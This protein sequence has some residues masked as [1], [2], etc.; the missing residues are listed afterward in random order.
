MRDLVTRIASRA[1]AAKDLF[2]VGDW[3]LY[4]KYKNKKGKVK[5]FGKDEKGN[6]TVTVEPHPNE[7]GRK[8]PKTLQLF[9]IWKMPEAKEPTKKASLASLQWGEPTEVQAEKMGRTSTRFPFEV[10]D[11]ELRNPPSLDFTLWELGVLAQAAQER[12]EHLRFIQIADQD[13]TLLFRELCGSLGVEFPQADLE[14]LMEEA[15]PLILKLKFHW[16]RARPHQVAESH[17]LRFHAMPSLSAKSPAYPS[18]H[19]IQAQLVSQELIRRYPEHADIIKTMADK[20]SWTRV[21]AGYHWP[22]DLVYGEEVAEFMWV[23]QVEDN[24][25]TAAK[26]KNKKQVDK[27]DGSGKTTVY[28]YSEK[29]VQHRNREKAKRVEGLRKNI[30][31]LRVQVKKDV[32]SSDPST[33]LTALAVALIDETYERVGN[34]TSAKEGHFGVTGW[35]AGHVSFSGS[36]ATVSYVG[37][38]GVKQKKTVST[39][40]IVSALKAAVKGKG[41]EENVLCEG[42]DCNISASEVNAYLKPHGVTAKDLRGFHANESMK[43]HLKTIRKDGPKLPEDKKEREKLLKDEFKKALEEA[44]KDVGHEASTLKSQYLVPGLEDDYV[45]DGTINE[46]HASIQDAWGAL[47]VA[48]KSD[49]EKQEEKVEDLSKPAPKKK[50]PRHDLRKER[51]EDDDDD[52]KKDKDKKDT[53]MNYKDI[54]ASVDVLLTRQATLN[55][56]LGAAGDVPAKKHG[57]GDVWQ[58]DNGFRAIPAGGDPKKDGKTFKSQEEAKAYAQGGEDVSPEEEKSPEEDSPEGEEKTKPKVKKKDKPKK[59][60]KPAK[61]KPEDVLSVGGPLPSGDDSAPS[62]DDL[63]D[64]T[65]ATFNAYLKSS[66]QDREKALGLIQDARDSASPDSP[67]HKHL[68]AQMQ[69]LLL[70]SYVNDESVDD[71]PEPP[72]AL[73]GLMK[74]LA[75]GG[76]EK[77]VALAASLAGNPTTPDARKAITDGI[78]GMPANEL[79]T[80]A[81]DDPSMAPL[82]DM[83]TSGDKDQEAA[84]ASAMAR[85]I[86]SDAAFLVPSVHAL[87]DYNPEPGKTNPESSK[88]ADEV[89]AEVKASV[90]TQSALGAAFASA[91]VEDG[92][93]DPEKFESNFMVSYAKS[94]LDA[95]KAKFPTAPSDN[96]GM[97]MLETISEGDTS[98]ADQDTDPPLQR[99]SSLL[100][101]DLEPWGDFPSI[102][103]RK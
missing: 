25:R 69:A 26:Y 29:Q 31:K 102:E 70:A 43:S 45:K 55:W 58:T 24:T 90:D 34:D 67:E 76:S 23:N 4:G 17:G 52:L 50:P 30:D 80:I 11:L 82:V 72:H 79:A 9:R 59:P 47:L 46:K 103:F 73:R 2:E 71:T 1:L 37:K 35:Q 62:E 39:P 32:K 64:R 28:E 53:S 95:L 41:K 42:D 63:Q 49:E 87:I 84:A 83:L 40:W 21:Q 27:A 89:V 51:V 19:T 22:S 10:S 5:S 97:K 3:I 91:E 98:A 56:I 38:S 57:P 18:G 15:E 48:T 99:S 74:F 8:Q 14:S 60:K 75:K 7:S 12:A 66:T 94:L 20:I 65:N 77:E 81:K 93:V 13:F 96:I 68:T 85:M 86:S 33:R 16:N 44:A 61:A 100:S 92:T 36:K 88:K 101:Y 78:K 6:I 54:G